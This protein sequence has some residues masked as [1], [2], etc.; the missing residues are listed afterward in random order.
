MTTTEKPSITIQD[1]IKQKTI[2]LPNYGEV[3]IVCHDGK[4]KLVETTHK[5]QM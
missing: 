3:K 2:T 5:E 4:V 1:G